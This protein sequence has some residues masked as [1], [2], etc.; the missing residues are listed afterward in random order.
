AYWSFTDAI[1]HGNTVPVFGKGL[2]RRDFTY[3]DDIVAGLAALIEGEYAAGEGA[4]HRIYNLG[5]SHP[6]SVL[7]LL[8][9][10]ERA[11]GK[12]TKIEYR[13]GPPGDVNETY[14]DV[15]KAHRDFGFTPKVSLAEGIS[16]FVGWYR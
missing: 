8:G 3:V 15:S 13:D 7:D 12:K 5:N 2:L 9:H 14:A 4:P 11:T 1:L 10:I 16:R 6:E